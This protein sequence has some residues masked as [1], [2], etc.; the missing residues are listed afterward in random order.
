MKR[1]AVIFSS[2]VIVS[3][4][5]VAHYARSTA[6]PEPG[7][8][9]GA[10]QLVFVELFTSEGCSSC[11]PAD[12]LLKELSEEQSVRG[13]H[14]VALEEHVDYW[15]RLGWTDPF[16]SAE[17]S[18][19][20][21]EYA[22]VFGNGGVYT[23][24]MIVDGQTEFVGSHSLRAREAIHRAAAVPKANVSLKQSG[25]IESN[26]AA[27]EVKLERSSSAPAVQNAELWLAVTEKGRQTEV[28]AGENSGERLQHAAIVRR[29]SKIGSVPSSGEFT[30]QLKVKLENGWK[31]EN[32]SIV[33]LL[34]EKPSRKI[35]GGGV[36]ALKEGEIT[37]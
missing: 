30:N 22:Q 14:V 8:E 7:Q 26:S 18:Q 36:L 5:L 20:Q 9:P 27:I 24:Q 15:N 28:T 25:R 17:F 2:L 23:P 32:L 4:G 37:K 6:L 21:D 11:P 35:V 12:S 34:V 1:V 33:A 19:R 3:F 31:V 29:L 10:K 13:A 16:S